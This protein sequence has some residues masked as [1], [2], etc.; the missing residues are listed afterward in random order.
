MPRNHWKIKKKTGY[1][2]G[3]N[4]RRFNVHQRQPS[5]DRKDLTKRRER[6]RDIGT[7]PRLPMR[8]GNESLRARHVGETAEERQERCTWVTLGF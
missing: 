2:V 7:L 6:D 8:G 4:E 3:E 1:S 5:K